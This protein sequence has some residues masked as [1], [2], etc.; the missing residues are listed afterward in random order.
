LVYTSGDGTMGIDYIGL[1][2]VIIDQLKKLKQ[3]LKD[4][5]SRIDSL[6]QKLNKCCSSSGSLKSA[7]ITTSVESAE[8]NASNVATLSQNA[9]NPFSQSTNIG[10][11][12]PVSVQNAT[13][14]IYDMNGV[15]IKSI[16]VTSKGIGTITIDGYELRPGMYLYTLI[17]DNI[18]VATKRMILTQ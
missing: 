9:P 12:L 8:I 10:Y 4:K 16:P 7:K 15:Q 5:D 1:I 14:Y 3:S 18:E 6:K 13:L 11:Y 2:P 17:A